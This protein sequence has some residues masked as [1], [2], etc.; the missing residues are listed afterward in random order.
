MVSVILF[1]I[2]I[3]ASHAESKSGNCRI[4]T[5]TVKSMPGF[6][7]QSV[8]VPFHI[9]IW[10]EKKEI[11]FMILFLQIRWLEIG[12]LCKQPKEMVFWIAVNQSM[13]PSVSNN[14]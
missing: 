10:I 4:G 13:N 5:S 9:F 1:L 11:K 8:R 3:K 7:I 12:T 14:H 2:A 6:K